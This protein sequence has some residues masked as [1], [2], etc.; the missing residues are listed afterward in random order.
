MSKSDAVLFAVRAMLKDRRSSPGVTIS[1][2]YNARAKKILV[3][4]M[5]FDVDTA[6]AINTIIGAQQAYEEVEGVNFIPPN[7]SGGSERGIIP[8]RRR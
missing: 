8:D 5:H 4:G 7:K 2:T 6:E 1:A 3:R